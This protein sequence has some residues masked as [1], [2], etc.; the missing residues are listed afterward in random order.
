MRHA[1][2]GNAIDDWAGGQGARAG[3]EI[4]RVKDLHV[5]VIGSACTAETAAT[6]AHGPVVEENGYGVVVARNRRG[7]QLLEGIG[8]WIE[9]FRD[10]LGRGV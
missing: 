7:S 1:C 9:K 8:G 10:V 3:V 4:R 5:K 2:G 6:V